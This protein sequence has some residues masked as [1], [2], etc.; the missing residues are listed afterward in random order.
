[1]G[2]NTDGVGHDNSR[3]TKRNIARFTN[4]LDRI[5]IFFSLYICKLYIFLIIILGRC[6]EQ[7]FPHHRSI[8]SACPAKAPD[9]TQAA[10][11]PHFALQNRRNSPK[12]LPSAETHRTSDEERHAPPRPEKMHPTMA[13]TKSRSRN[14]L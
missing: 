14:R 1:M 7:E 6:D 10:S 13:K 11:V 3:I 9:N 12:P 8:Q 4:S 5:V 2:G